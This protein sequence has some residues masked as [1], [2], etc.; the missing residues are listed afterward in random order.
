[1]AD[2]GDASIM[3][4]LG[5][6]APEEAHTHGVPTGTV[7]PEPVRRKGQRAYAGRVEDL[8]SAGLVPSAEVLARLVPGLAAVATAAA[9]DAAALRTLI[10]EH[11]RA[12]RARRSLLLLHLE[13]QV[14]IDELPWISALARHR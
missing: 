8:V 12:F 4:M 5:P 7:V 2:R 13:H 14:R 6:V 3:D 9:Y 1:A 11:Y 10:A